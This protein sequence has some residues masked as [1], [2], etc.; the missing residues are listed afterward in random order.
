VNRII[1][2]QQCESTPLWP[3]LLRTGAYVATSAA[4]TPI[5]EEL[6]SSASRAGLGCFGAVGSPGPS[7]LGLSPFAQRTQLSAAVRSREANARVADDTA[8]TVLQRAAHHL[9][10]LAPPPG[11]S[12]LPAFGASPAPI[13]SQPTEASTLPT[14]TLW[15]VLV[16]RVA[17][18]G[19]ATRTTIA[20]ELGAGALAGATVLVQ[21]Y[22]GRVTV[23]LDVPAHADLGALRSRIAARL[24][25]R[26]LDV[27]HVEVR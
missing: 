12:A 1:P 5:R 21:S 19:D 4:A 24:A 22:N 20:L 17:W 2:A 16:R 3:A 6:C 10:Q 23:R 7:R 11:S 13:R 9:A 14:E 15:S 18:A 8:D 25:A 27:D 26:G